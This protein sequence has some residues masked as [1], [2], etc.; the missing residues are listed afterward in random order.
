MI[1]VPK[2]VSSAQQRE[3]DAKWMYATEESVGMFS[4]VALWFAYRLREKLNVPVGI[5][6]SSWGG[7]FAEAWTSRSTLMRNPEVRNV[8]LEYESLLPASHSWGKANFFQQLPS[9]K[10]EFFQK[11]GKADPGNAGLGRG[12]A[13]PS[14]DDSSWKKIQIPGSWITQKIAG[15]G[16]VWG[17]VARIDPRTLERTEPFPASGRNRQTGYYLF[18]RSRG[19]ALRQ[20]IR[21]SLLE[22]SA[23]LRGARGAGA[24]GRGRDRGPRLLLP[25]RRGVQWSGRD[26][27]PASGGR[28]GGCP[29]A[30]R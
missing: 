13:E 1:T 10:Q 9:S 18:Q 6:H 25:V 11:Y 23:Q 19:R 20:R 17:P 29:F 5:I 24:A 2:S 15:N 3:F 21:G 14:F 26:V 8:L 30:C 16:V 28:S 12:W 7:T 27:P 22:R 4:A